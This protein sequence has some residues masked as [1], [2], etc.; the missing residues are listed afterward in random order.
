[1]PSVTTSVTDLPQSRVRVRAEV[2]PEEVERR[3]QQAARRLGAQLRVPGFRKG[4]VPPA[5]VIRRLGRGAVLDEA[6]RESLGNW[7]VDAIDGSGIAPIGD[8]D[9]DVGDP[10]GQGEPW[11]FSIE[12]GVRPTA[13]LGEYAG[14]EVARREPH[15]DA[16]AVDAEIA[17]LRDQFATLETV[18]R[19]ADPGD[20]LVADYVGT[21]DGEPFEGGTGRDQLIELGSGKL[22]PGFEEQLTGA[23]AGED[24]TLAVTFP[25]DYPSELAGR[26]ARFEVHVHEVKAKRLPELDDEFAALASDFDTIDELRAD[27][28]RRL[29]EADERTIEREF[30]QAVLEAAVDNAHVEVPE[31]L[32]HARAHEMVE[33]M[34]D[35]LARQG[36][37]RATYLRIAGTDEHSL[38]HEAE[39]EAAGALR[40]EAVLAA[41]V[42]AE[43]IAPSDA[44]LIAAL[45]PAAEREGA[46]PA[47]L[48][49]KLDEHRREHLREDV[50]A[51]QALARLVAS[52]T[53]ISV[54][55]ASAREALWT[56]GKGA[57]EGAKSPA[58]PGDPGGQLWTPGS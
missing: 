20:Q 45:A 22:I 16:A 58:K 11:S 48:L 41:I 38:A 51:R 49:P 14:L 21:V 1:M 12:V 15:V 28:E 2:A 30:E 26:D 9:L 50:A 7:Y 55:K 37:D 57:E 36:I 10:P 35:S 47:A 4:K 54:E 24:R 46:D 8:P 25:D 56:P 6:L 18:Q 3:V 5:V 27:I 53:P 32:V 44:D 31:P 39:S 23:T 52:A 17:R 29:R 42:A 33:Q 13:T 19:P 43:Q 34:L 40:R